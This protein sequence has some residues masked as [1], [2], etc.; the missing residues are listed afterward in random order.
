MGFSRSRSLKSQ[1]LFCTEEVLRIVRARLAR[2]SASDL[3]TV[4][5]HV[6]RQ[7]RSELDTQVSLRVVA[8]IK[9]LLNC[10]DASAKGVTGLSTALQQLT[11]SINVPALY[12]QFEAQFNSVISTS[13]YK[14]L[15]GLYNRKSLPSQISS[16]LGLK[17]GELDRT[18]CP[19]CK[20]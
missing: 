13:D 19:P 10:L 16:A 4:V 5:T 18:C 17:S 6:T 11:Q 8:E 3:Q 1:N 7:L 2:D 14:A 20:N 15:L 9:F 12:A